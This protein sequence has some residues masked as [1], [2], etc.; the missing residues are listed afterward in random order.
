MTM[1]SIPL[2]HFLYDFRVVYQDATDRRRELLYPIK[3]EAGLIGA[4]P[5]LHTKLGHYRF[6]RVFA[7]PAASMAQ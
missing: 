3:P 4:Q 2:K 7:L 5:A 6:P 1:G